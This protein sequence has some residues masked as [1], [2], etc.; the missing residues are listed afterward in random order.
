MKLS[1][2]ALVRAENPKAGGRREPPFRNLVFVTREDGRR[3]L[4][5]LT[6]TEAARAE[7]RGAKLADLVEL[8]PA[9]WL[10]RLFGADRG[11]PADPPPAAE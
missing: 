10:R 6:D 1:L 8:K 4:L 3:V 5:A 2:G 7:K 11:G 9:G